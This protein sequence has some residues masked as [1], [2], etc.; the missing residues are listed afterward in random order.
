MNFKLELWDGISKHSTCVGCIGTFAGFAYI[1][2]PRS[3]GVVASFEDDGFQPTVSE[4]F[5][6][7]NSALEKSVSTSLVELC[8]AQEDEGDGANKTY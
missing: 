8:Q 3:P 7:E 4:R 1:P 5:Q 2:P 6:H